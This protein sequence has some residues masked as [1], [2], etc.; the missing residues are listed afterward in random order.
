MLR[1][2]EALLQPNGQIQ[3]LDHPAESSDSPR[4]VLVT[5]T[6]DTEAPVKGG[7]A[8]PADWRDLVGLLKAS[9]HWAGDPQTV[10]QA[11]RDEWN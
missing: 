5:F 3:F 2:Y 11:M 10:Q 6:E 7:Q 8:E 1:T 9:P 4:H